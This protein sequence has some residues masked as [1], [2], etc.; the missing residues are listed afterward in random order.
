MLGVMRP[1][2][3]SQA[4]LRQG[5]FTVA[6]ARQAGVRWDALQTKI[7]TR[8][9]RGQYAWTGIPRDASL[10]MRAVAE[11]MPAAHAFSGLTA[12]WLLGFDFPWC[13]PIE[14]AIGREVPVRARTG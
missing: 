4:D 13:E 2:S 9:S 5:P 14:V 7:W 10:K 3:S 6:D 11:R 8:M 1:L 12:A